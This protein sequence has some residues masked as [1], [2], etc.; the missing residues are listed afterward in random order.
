[1]TANRLPASRTPAN[2]PCSHF[3][4]VRSIFH[5]EPHEKRET[6]NEPILSLLCRPRA[7]QNVRSATSFVD[8]ISH[9][10]FPALL[11]GLLIPLCHVQNVVVSLMLQILMVQ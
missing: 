11:T 4:A 5:I 9:V 10:L 7:A 6:V 3:L 1:M 8:E 2:L